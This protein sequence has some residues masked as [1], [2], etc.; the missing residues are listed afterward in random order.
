MKYNLAETVASKTD[1]QIQAMLKQRVKTASENWAILSKYDLDLPMEDRP[2]KSRKKIKA[3]QSRMEDAI[4]WIT[5][6]SIYFADEKWNEMVLQ[7]GGS[8]EE[9]AKEPA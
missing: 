6:C 4:D 9:Y 7:A 3:A 5:D 8:L 2:V 1:A